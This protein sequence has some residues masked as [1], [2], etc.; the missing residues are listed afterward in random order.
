MEKI[1]VSKELAEMLD[2]LW[3]GNSKE[4]IGKTVINIITMPPHNLTPE[5]QFVQKSFKNKW[6][7]LMKA[8]TSGYEAEY[9]PEEELRKLYVECAYP[10]GSVETAVAKAFAYKKAA[11]IMG[12]DTSDWGKENEI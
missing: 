1:K 3:V 4:T 6:F 10:E 5:A 9:T 7:D 2:R 12:I 11:E 8:A